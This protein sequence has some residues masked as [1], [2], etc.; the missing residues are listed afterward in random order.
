MNVTKISSMCLGKTGNMNEY[1]S[2]YFENSTPEQVLEF[3]KEF[4]KYN[5]VKAVGY[6]RKA[7]LS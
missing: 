1:I 4:E 2:L 6:N 7:K 3:G 5:C